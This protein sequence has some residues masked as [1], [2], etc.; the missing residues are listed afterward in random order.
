MTVTDEIRDPQRFGAALRLAIRR[1]ARQVRQRPLVSIPALILPGIGDI[2]V[3]YAPPLVVAR[4]LGAFARDERLSARELAPFVLVFAGLWLV[5]E[6]FW[7]IAA[8]FIARAEI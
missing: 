1:Y 5:G 3:L 7:R 2:L 4:L 8:P 6:V